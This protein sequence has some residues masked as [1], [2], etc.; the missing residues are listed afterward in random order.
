M[1]DAYAVPGVYITES[2]NLALSIQSGETAVPVFV[3][4]FNPLTPP[5]GEEPHC[6]R[7]ESWLDFTSK[8]RSSDHIQGPRDKSA[9]KV[10]PYHGSYSVRLHFENG[11]GPCYVLF[12]NLRDDLDKPAKQAL[13]GPVIALYPDIT[14]LCWCEFIS[15]QLD[16]TIYAV[17]DA[18]LGATATSGGNRG[19]FLLADARVDGKSDGV[20]SG[21]KFKVPSV[22]N[23]TQVAAYFPALKTSYTRDYSD[24]P[25]SGFTEDEFTLLKSGGLFPDVDKFTSLN[26]RGARRGEVKAALEKA[27]KAAGDTAANAAGSDED[28]KQK[29]RGEA[30]KKARDT[31]K[32][33]TDFETNLQQAQ[34]NELETT[35]YARASVAM[36]GVYARVDRERG[37]WKAPA[38]VAL[39]GVTGLVADGFDSSNKN[40]KWDAPVP[41]KVDD[42]LNTSLT[43]SN[44]NTLREFRGRGTLVWGARTMEA[45]VNKDWLYVPV[46]RL[47]NA[48]ERD[49]RAALRQA[50]FEPNSPATWAAVRSALESYLH[51]LWRK[52]AL[53][54]ETP[55]QAYQVLAGPGITMTPDDITDGRLK[56]KVALAAVRP[57]EF[58]VLE[59]SQLIAA[60]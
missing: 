39:S 17:L 32:P 59:L 55:E 25:L 19:T 40:K 20:V 52:G 9:G 38:N 2:N 53:Q 49:A 8:F 35:V 1:S 7:I 36:A 54:G 42:A 15:S 24:V 41:V 30:E 60:G 46:R 48:V 14:L 50:V 4:V 3:G 51:D 58:I 37:V 31:A 27:V 10:T 11:G 16:D 33:L 28:A 43:G 21:W 13:I 22:N 26:G 44:I 34:K 12:F 29:A 6:V 18:Q 5:E 45:P 56:I 57:A 23:P 47:F